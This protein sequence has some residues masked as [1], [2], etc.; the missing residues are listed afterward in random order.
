MPIISRRNFFLLGALPWTRSLAQQPDFTTGVRVV[1]ILASVRDKDGHIV[2]DLTQD[3][4]IIEEKGHPQVIQ[5]FARQS[6]LPLTLGL[7]VDVSGSQRTVLEPQR[8]ASLQFL[9]QVLREGS[10]WAFLLAFDREMDLLQDVT[11]SRAELDSGLQKLA[12]IRD[13][14]GKL[15]E[16][17]QGTALYN[18]V[19]A[20][21]QKVMSRQ[22][23]RKALIVLSDGVDTN[24]SK[25]L[26]AAVDE[27][28]REDTLIYTIRFY[29]QRLLAF[30]VAGD[31]GPRLRDGK[32]VLL[33]M[34]EQTGGGYFE[35]PDMPALEKIFASIEE[36]LRNQ[37]SLGYSPAKGK[38]GYR[39]ISVSTKRKG[40]TVQA[41]DGYFSAG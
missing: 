29:D 31:T 13:P 8:E 27:C 19:F 34:S 24:S 38:P 22:H 11:T 37:Y 23:G 14:S 26:S 7:L 20:A 36:E 40:L 35:L 12:L 2:T 3:D 33:H 10:D 4:F 21:A 16:H 15:P 25:S 1:N 18:A 9:H 17:A 6:G 32:K 5:Y 41:R 39:K 28:Q 30:P